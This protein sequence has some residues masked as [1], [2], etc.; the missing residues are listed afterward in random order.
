M[1]TRTDC[2]AP[3]CWSGGERDRTGRGGRHGSRVE[4]SRGGHRMRRCRMQLW[5]RAG[6]AD[7]RPDHGPCSRP[8]RGCPQEMTMRARFREEAGGTH[9]AW[10]TPPADA[11]PSGR[12]PWLTGRSASPVRESRSDGGGRAPQPAREGAWIQSEAVRP[13]AGRSTAEGRDQDPRGSRPA[14]CE[15][16]RM[17]IAP[18]QACKGMGYREQDCARKGLQTHSRWRRQSEASPRKQRLRHLG[19][20]KVG[21]RTDTRRKPRGRD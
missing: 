1:S 20:L 13:P 10:P 6:G 16:G 19:K 5:R 2:A 3:A 8:S 14:A 9:A 21:V 18:L 11:R 15:P 7:S 4:V 12:V 17:G